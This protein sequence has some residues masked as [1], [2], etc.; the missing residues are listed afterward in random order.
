MHN[1]LYLITKQQHV[2]LV[3]LLASLV[4]ASCSQQSEV[5]PLQDNEEALVVLEGGGITIDRSQNLAIITDM[6]AYRRAL[7][8]A[9]ERPTERRDFDETGNYLPVV[10][11]YAGSEFRYYDRSIAYYK[12][13]Y[14]IN[15]GGYT[16]YVAKNELPETLQ[17][18]GIR[19]AVVAPN[20][21]LELYNQFNDDEPS[22]T[23][24]SQYSDEP[25]YKETVIASARY[26]AVRCDLTNAERTKNPMCGLAYWYSNYS[27]DPLPI[28]GNIDENF[29]GFVWNDNID[30]YWDNPVGSA[31]R[32]CDG[33]VM[34]ENSYKGLGDPN[35]GRRLWSI[36]ESLAS[37][38]QYPGLSN[39]T[40]QIVSVP[41]NTY[42]SLDYGQSLALL[43]GLGVVN[44][45]G[46]VL[47]TGKTDKYK[48][49][50]SAGTCNIMLATCRAVKTAFLGT[51]SIGGS[52]FCKKKYY[53]TGSLTSEV[54]ASIATLTNAATDDTSPGDIE[55]AGRLIG[56]E[57]AAQDASGT[58]KNATNDLIR[59]TGCMIAVGSATVFTHNI[60]CT[61]LE[62]SCGNW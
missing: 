28:Y 48:K 20:C 17:L 50:W 14:P 43:R 25:N 5:I 29:V 38:T 4:F 56:D 7:D 24:S 52:I 45:A 13:L 60:D 3:C 57:V 31:D 12:Y 36:D 2:L 19:S 41:C 44:E 32:R 8:N 39:K 18:G 33:L 22:W 54:G 1:I 40:S 55:E 53:P 26:Y 61:I 62:N 27:G 37:F 46:N 10:T 11:F 6:D 51:C 9:P 34:Y 15:D 30:S 42:H 16:Y 47:G 21:V 58:T 49:N 35:N 23:S 59:Y